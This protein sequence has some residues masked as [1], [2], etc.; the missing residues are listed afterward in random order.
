MVFWPKRYKEKA[1]VVSPRQGLPKTKPFA[2][3]HMLWSFCVLL[4]MVVEEYDA[5]TGDNYPGTMRQSPRASWRRQPHRSQPPYTLFFE[6]VKDLSF[7]SIPYTNF[8]Q[9]KAFLITNTQT[10][11]SVNDSQCMPR[12]CPRPPERT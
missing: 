7:L 9:H 1:S 2:I 3:L 11:L 4:V 6:T 5:D 12:L 10:V 8:L